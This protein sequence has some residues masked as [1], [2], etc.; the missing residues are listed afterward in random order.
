[1]KYEYI[2]TGLQEWLVQYERSQREIRI[3]KPVDWAKYQGIAEQLHQEFLN[4]VLADQVEQVKT[5]I[6]S[7]E[8]RKRMLIP[9]LFTHDVPP[10]WMNALTSQVRVDSESNHRIFKILV[11]AYYQIAKLE[12]MWDL[13]RYSYSKHMARIE[14]RMNDETRER[15]R[16]Y[17]SEEQPIEYL[18]AQVREPANE[19][20]NDRLAAYWISEDSAYYH[21]VFLEVVREATVAFFQRER[22]IYISMFQRG[23]NQERQYLAQALIQNCKLDH[24]AEMARFLFENMSTY[25]RKPMLWN[26]VRQ[27]EKEKFANW[28]MRKTLHDF[29][30]GLD[31]DHERFRYWE[32][33]IGRMS[34]A[35]ILGNNGNQPTLLMYYPDV[36]IMEVLGNGAVYVYRVSTFE[37]HFQSRISHMLARREMAKEQP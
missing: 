2:P 9:F 16:K 25:R 14:R 32:K 20:Y 15:W 5:W 4:L 24:V 8:R 17:L 3:D 18:A 10:V 19:S 27:Q 7:L 33:F 31:T 6:T 23:S 26:Q 28:I 11:E 37:K 36:I 29:F 35:V 22:D 21:K 34:E 30:H 13:V 12:P 1:M